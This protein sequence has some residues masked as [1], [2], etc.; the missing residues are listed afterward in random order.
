MFAYLFNNTN[1]GKPMTAP[2]GRRVSD[3]EIKELREALNSATLMNKDANDRLEDAIGFTLDVRHKLA[4]ALKI[5]E[6]QKGS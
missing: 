2:S 6:D 1:R 4:K 5:L 3:A